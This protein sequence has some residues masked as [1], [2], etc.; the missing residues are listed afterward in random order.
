MSSNHRDFASELDQARLTA[1]ALGQLLEPERAAVESQLAALEPEKAEKA[2]QVVE[3]IRALAG[4]IVEASRQEPHP[5]SSPDLRAAVES[6]LNQTEDF[7]M[8]AQNSPSTNVAEPGSADTGSRKPKRRNWAR[9]AVVACLLIAAVAV[10]HSLGVFSQ[11]SD[12][13]QIAMS[14]RSSD[15]KPL[16]TI[17]PGPEGQTLSEQSGGDKLARDAGSKD[18]ELA[19]AI[20]PTQGTEGRRREGHGA[21]DDAADR[22]A[23]MLAESG[24]SE[25]ESGSYRLASDASRVA[26]RASPTG[27]SYSARPA[28]APV[29]PG[30]GVAGP[31][32]GAGGEMMGSGGYGSEYYDDES[33]SGAMMGVARQ[34]GQASGGYGGMGGMGGMGDG[35]MYG[36]EFGY[37]SAGGVHF[38]DPHAGQPA[39]GEVRIEKITGTAFSPDGRP[40]AS[41]SSSDRYVKLW[42]AEPNRGYDSY[43]LDESLRRR[44][45]VPGTEQYD[46]IPENEFLPA[47]ANPLSTFSIDVD[48]ASYTNVRRFLG[49]GRLPPP[50]AVRIEEMVNYFRYDYP[51][52]DDEV[53]FSVN[54]EVAQ[55]PWQP[56][57]RLIRVG[58]KG[59]QIERDQR[60][61]CNLVFLLD[62]SG[63][64]S[65][66]DKLPLVQQAM[67]LLV[68]QLTEDDRVA[69]VT[70][71]GN[72]GLKLES[73]N[74]ENKQTILDAIDSLS[75]GGSTHGSAGIQLAYEQAAQHFVEEG[76]NRV[77]LATDGDLNVGVTQDDE[78][79]K[80]I[81]KKAK[82][83]VFL[84]VLG[85]GTGNLKDSKMEKLAD[86][87][88]GNYAYVDN[89][90]EA[91]KILVEQLSGSLVTI[92]KDVKI[93]IEFNP[94]EVYAYRLI[95]YENRVLA[96]ED[97]DN[98]KKDAGEIGAGH[99]VTALYELVPTGERESGGV[100]GQMLKY[101]R[102]REKPEMELTEEASG[103]ELLTLR[104]RYK[105][106]DGKKSQLLE[107]VT[108]DSEKRFGQSSPD[109]QFAAAVASFGML[110]RGS[111]YSGQITLAAVEEF[112]V[113][114]VG[115]DPGGYRVEFVD[116]VR[117]ARQLRP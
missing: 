52:P 71:A 107:F 18:D 113:S 27:P 78:L 97:F 49:E 98:D 16:S 91:R 47:D 108:E 34:S 106:P 1:Y 28:D 58:L 87:G 37:G 43:G 67:T 32:P 72:A 11:L 19:S 7:Q 56:E 60:G 69:I 25:G 46:K 23:E 3:Q 90:R 54:M 105:Q 77:I 95:G 94:S 29:A 59:R 65:S 55:C 111:R 63:S 88:N 42:D 50:N 35:D 99:T 103:G 66:Q 79:V 41:A 83:G 10:C 14:D 48:T 20:L 86:H 114:G 116:L 68:D 12:N 70:Y 13:L 81:Q 110:L 21:P 92:A 30:S 74:G 93:Q 9:L 40:L 64:M 62:V 53:P 104:L 38:I 102:P 51:Q 61:P 39:S 80:L 6:R 26:E 4:Q 75:S 82:S 17:F 22:L 76:T 45:N 109:F 89:L 100:Q 115:D 85:F 36:E 5:R 2:R 44:H 57:H 8:V 15:E 31:G 24:K 84:T 117:R 101:Q 96:A 112:A 33:G 73:T